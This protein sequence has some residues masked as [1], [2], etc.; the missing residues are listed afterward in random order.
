MV[1]S[2][3]K[4]E[5][6]TSKKT[7]KRNRVPISCVICRRRKVKC[8]K[9]KPQCENCIK[10]NV[11]HL[12]HYLEPKWAQPLPSEMQ[13][14]NI[15]AADTGRSEH[16]EDAGAGNKG[17]HSV[18][19]SEQSG[20]I[21]REEK[22][23]LQKELELLKT[24]IKALES[25]NT[26][27]KRKKA[28]SS[29]TPKARIKPSDLDEVLDA[30]FNSNILFIAQESNQYNI[31][32]TYQISVFSWMFIVKNDFYLNDL[33]MKILKLRRH[34]EYYYNSRE[35]MDKNMISH[36]KNYDNRLSKLKSN[37]PLT[38]SPITQDKTT[39]HT[40]K[41]KKF[42]EKSLHLDN[43]CVNIKD[44]SNSNEI[45]ISTSTSFKNLQNTSNTN[46]RP[47]VCP[48]T[49]VVGVCPMGNMNAN[50][51]TKAKIQSKEK[52]AVD[53]NSITNSSHQNLTSDAGSILP[54]NSNA[55]TPTDNDV[56]YNDSSSITTDGNRTDE[57]RTLK[58]QYPS[59]LKFNKCPVLHPHDASLTPTYTKKSN[60][61]TLVT[62]ATTDNDMFSDSDEL[63]DNRVCPLMIGDAKA[64]FKAKLSKYN[65][66]ALRGSYGNKRKSSSASPAKS[67]GIP[68]IPSAPSTPMSEI[69]PQDS[70]K[71]NNFVPIAMKV[72]PSLSS[73]QNSSKRKSETFQ[74]IKSKKLKSI[75]PSFIKSLNYNNTKQILTIIEQYLPPKKV[76]CLLVDRF[77]DILYIYMPY[78]DENSFRNRVSS[79]LKSS[80]TNSQKIKLS[81]IGYQYGED[82]L[83]LCLLLIITRLSWLSLPEKSIPGLTQNELLLMKP[84]NFVSFVLVDMVKE[85]FSNAK[86]MTK[87]SII[88]FQV[89]LFLKIYST[90]SPEDGF[91]TD[92]SYTR[93]TSYTSSNQNG[94]PTPSSSASNVS[95]LS[96]DLTNET[97]NM[98]SPLFISMLVQL[99]HTIG[100]NRDPLNFK[101]FYPN[102]NDDE[103]TIATLFKKR[104]LW[105]KLWFGLVFMTIEANLSLGDYK[106]GLPIE[107][108]LDPTLGSSINKSW[109]CRLPGGIEQGVLENCFE[110]GKGLQRELCVVQIFRESI[111]SYKWIYKGMKVLFN[112]DTPPTTVE[113]ENVI[114]KLSEI[115]CEKSKY[116]YGIDLILGEQEIVNPFRARNSSVWVKK[117]MKQIKVAR[118]KV[119]LIVK[120]MI[121]TLNYLLLLNHEQKLSK[122]LGQRQSSIEKIEKQRIYIE[123]FFESS[124][125]SAIENFKLFI[126]FM[127]DS[128]K[129]FPNCS[130]ELLLYP[131][132]MILNHRSHEFLISLILRVQQSSPVIMEILKKNIIDPKELQKRLFTYLETFIE[133][134][135]ILTKRYYYAWVLKRL[136]KFFFNILT[137]SQK[138]FKLNFKRMAV[139]PKNSHVMSKPDTHSNRSEDM[140]AHKP[141]GGEKSAFEIAFGTSKLPPV[142][143]LTHDDRRE[144]NFNPIISNSNVISSSAKTNTNGS[145][146][147]DRMNAGVLHVAST[148]RKSNTVSQALFQ[149]MEA[150]LNFGSNVGAMPLNNMVSPVLSF[151]GFPLPQNMNSHSM[152]A[153]SI[154]NAL[155]LNANAMLDEWNGGFKEE[156]TELFDD[157]FLNEIGGFAMENQD[158]LGFNG[159]QS[160]L[161]DSVVAN[162]SNGD[163]TGYL[164]NTNNSQQTR[165]LV[166]NARNPSGA[167]SSDPLS[168][169]RVASSNSLMNGFFNTQLNIAGG[170]TAAAGGKGEMY[171][172]L[173]EIDFTNVDL[174]TPVDNLVYGFDVNMVAN[175]SSTTNGNTPGTAHN[176]SEVN[177]HG[178]A[179]GLGSWNFF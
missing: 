159:S 20:N 36:Y 101:N 128:T 26:D 68:M 100:L 53:E 12:C 99:A 47:N 91:D 172:S 19:N 106:K 59:N 175:D 165:T 57:K 152:M 134:L 167:W 112:V 6:D 22:L 89:G 33:W 66:S 155:N 118:F 2:C 98:N 124:L 34:Y 71:L 32:I 3:I 177:G 65:I 145:A 80:D 113:I 63:E 144:I 147:E 131:F 18:G 133:R 14:Y 162:D 104:H 166:G 61:S 163:L 90:I 23:E 102:A 120:N 151:D 156:L 50:D 87:P 169:Q 76:V 110:S 164:A 94:T 25:E 96:G 157:G 138:L 149:N 136:V 129:V 141:G 108:D 95:D 11:Q 121:F 39:E 148:N 49:G 161:S 92:D 111:V 48:V 30:I 140:V 84:E 8:D 179:P 70:D 122:L 37:S 79:L 41:L 176:S 69:K 143:D 117:Y 154:S 78:V 126:Q 81:G 7:R 150:D 60:L 97:P 27:L 116:G 135:D 45:E 107:L 35:A 46:A 142:T 44:S 24:K 62:E 38:P 73:R 42:L 170:G 9:K 75:S 51:L 132:L 160:G 58:R 52:T 139:P 21:Y 103:N 17:D 31:P 130:A 83:T 93:N 123:K 119:H 29:N 1:E 109:D 82:F 125:L 86:I 16:G 171:N 72:E 158:G 13:N 114:S 153:S 40:S 178:P 168:R 56:D 64:L 85:I 74:P 55:E 115:I 88:I 146:V 10:N 43:N 67:K 173:N 28:V 137:N 174:N 15:A 105:R 4:N 127:D 77:F 5:K 54:H